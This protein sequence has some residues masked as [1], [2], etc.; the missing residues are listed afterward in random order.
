M[1][2]N[3]G[4]SYDGEWN[5]GMMSGKGKIYNNKGELVKDVTFDSNRLVY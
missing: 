1:H 5:G 3:T 4:E 2:W